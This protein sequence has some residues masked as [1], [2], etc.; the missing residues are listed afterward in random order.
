MSAITN[1]AIY[2]LIKKAFTPFAAMNM[3]KQIQIAKSMKNQ[4]LKLKE[5]KPL[6]LYT[7][8]VPNESEENAPKLPNTKYTM[9]A[10]ITSEALKSV[11]CDCAFYSNYQMICWHLIHLLE[12]L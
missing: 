1:S 6:T 12:K 4:R 11:T 7:L 9:K 5:V 2:L 8:K 10:S 3:L